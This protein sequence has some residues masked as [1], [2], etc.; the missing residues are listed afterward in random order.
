MG[1]TDP[2]WVLAMRVGEA[3]E[4][5][6]VLRPEKRETLTRIGKM[7]GL[8]AFDVSLVIAIVQD[9][10]RRGHPTLQAP[11]AG[12]DQ[13]AMIQLNS[14]NRK[15]AWQQ[16]LPAGCVV[17]AVIVAEVILLWAWLA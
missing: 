13:L 8:T 6:G 5:G 3:M 11:G 16:W 14:A 10:V 9:Q 15:P 1:A 2:R 7:L 4:P 17:A 12:A